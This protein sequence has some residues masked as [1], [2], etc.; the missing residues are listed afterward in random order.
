MGVCI[1]EAVPDLMISKHIQT[2]AAY[3]FTQGIQLYTEVGEVRWISED[4]ITSI[5]Y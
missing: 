2:E 3:L 1:W 5:A 4:L